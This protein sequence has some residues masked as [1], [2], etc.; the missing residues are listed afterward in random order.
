MNKAHK[1]TIRELRARIADYKAEI[2][3]GCEDDYSS[4]ERELQRMLKRLKKLLSKN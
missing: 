4:M 1:A 3:S 2:D